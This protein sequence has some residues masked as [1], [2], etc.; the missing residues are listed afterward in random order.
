MGDVEEGIALFKHVTSIVFDPQ[1]EKTLWKKLSIGKK[2]R[3]RE[4]RILSDKQGFA[5]GRIHTDEDANKV[6][7]MMFYLTNTTAT[8]Y[9]YGT[10]LHTTEQYYN[11]RQ[12]KFMRKNGV[13]DGDGDCFYK[14]QFLP[15]S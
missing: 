1:F 3:R 6:A 12:G 7:T 5:N 4:L 2:I 9:D 15:N 14:F 8:K 11:R 13:R 10:C